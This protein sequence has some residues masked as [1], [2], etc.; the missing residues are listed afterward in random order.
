MKLYNFRN[1][2]ND[3]DA[4]INCSLVTDGSDGHKKVFIT[5]TPRN[6][7]AE[8]VALGF[9]FKPGK[10]VFEHQLIKFATDAKLMLTVQVEDL[11][12]SIETLVELPEEPEA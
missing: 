11:T 9:V 3:E 1:A 2:L 8:I 4:T 10:T 7:N 5:E 6:L 12:D